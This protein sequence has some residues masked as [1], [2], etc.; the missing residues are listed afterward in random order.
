MEFLRKAIGADISAQTPST[1]KTELEQSNRDLA[2]VQVLGNIHRD[3][4]TLLDKLA[5]NYGVNYP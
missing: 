2:H 5:K 4:S 3:I 1:S